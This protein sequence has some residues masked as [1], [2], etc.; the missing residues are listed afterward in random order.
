MALDAPSAIAP[1][2]A[3]IKDLYEIGEMPPLGHVPKQMYA[4]A[5]RRER[6]GEPE[7][8]MQVEVVDTWA[9]DSNEVLVLVMA[10]GVNYNGIWAGEW[11]YVKLRG[12]VEELY[13]RGVDPYELSNLA[14]DRRFRAQLKELRALNEEFSDC[15]GSGCP[16]EFYS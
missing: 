16:V 7:T 1:Y 8:A 12:G 9:I 15:S 13:Y 2:D 3:P 11:T 10:A 6:H 4:W 14:G 5:I